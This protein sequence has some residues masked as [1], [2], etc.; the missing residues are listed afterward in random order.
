LFVHF[1]LAQGSRHFEQA[2][3]QRR[4]AV[5]DV[6]DDAEIPYELWVHVAQLPLGLRLTFILQLLRIFSYRQ[7]PLLSRTIRYTQPLAATLS[8]A[9]EQAQEPCRVSIQFATIRI[10]RLPGVAEN[11]TL[12]PSF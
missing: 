12:L 1:T 8:G 5:V 11:L 4:F 6:R 7:E 3:G 9:A 10:R 2:V